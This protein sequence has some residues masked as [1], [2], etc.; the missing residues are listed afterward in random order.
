MAEIDS[1]VPGRPPHLGHAQLLRA[2]QE[3]LGAP[4]RSYGLPARVLFWLLDF[5]YGKKHTL[6]KFK[7]LE[8]VARVPYR[9]VGR[10][11]ISRCEKAKA[12]EGFTR[13][14]LMATLSG[15]PLMSPRRSAST[16]RRRPRSRGR[17]SPM[18]LR[19]AP[20]RWGSRR[21]ARA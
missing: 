10:L 5:L 12:A 19:P 4:R 14:E 16:G 18:T 1:R 15:Q 8:L 3:T 2:Q 7:V 11:I 20:P 13:L 17:C 21:S 9:G 6:S